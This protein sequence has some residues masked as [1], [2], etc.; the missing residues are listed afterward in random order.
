MKKNL[1][2]R[3]GGEVERKCEDCKYWD[4]LDEHPWEPEGVKFN[5]IRKGIC[6]RYPPTVISTLNGLGE[7]IKKSEYV[8]VFATDWCGEYI[9]RR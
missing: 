5:P 1:F 7:S 9:D 4:L 6:R 2:G 3:S 8:I